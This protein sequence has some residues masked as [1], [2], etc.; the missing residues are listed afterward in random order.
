MSCILMYTG[1]YQHLLVLSLSC[2]SSFRI[3]FKKHKNIRVRI[4][5]I[6]NPKT[7]CHLNVYINIS[8][9]NLT[10]LKLP[11]ISAQRCNVRNTVHVL[12]YV[13]I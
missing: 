12:I 3:P 9:L 2:H 7:F 5:L 11:L 8:S 6:E 13:L 4:M 1:L 10:Y